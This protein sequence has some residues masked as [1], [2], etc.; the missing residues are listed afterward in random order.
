[1]ASVVVAVGV[2]A[3]VTFQ[4]TPQYA[5]SARLFVST[6]TGDSGEAYQ[7]SLFSAQRV[8][9]YADLAT[10]EELSRRVVEAN[11]LDMDADDLARQ[12][13][14]TVVPETV[15]LEITVTD[16]SPERAQRLAQAVASELTVFVAE[17]ERPEGRSNAPIKA[18][19]VD[20]A[21]SPE[22]PV[23][24]QPVRNLGLAAVLGLLLGLGLAVLR[25]LLDTSV[26]SQEDV[27]E[28]TGAPVMGH[29]SY[30]AGAVKKP[31]ITDLG[32]HAPRVEAFRVLRTNMQFVN[33]DS[34]SKVFVVTSSVPEEGKTTT[35]TNLAITL[36]QAGQRV[37]LIEADLR[38]PKISDNL[39]LEMVVGLTTVLVGRI[40]LED[41]VQ[42]FTVPNL[43]VLT[44]GAIP[45]NPSELLQSHAM[46]DVLDQARKMYDIIILDA[47]PLLPVTDAAL[48]TAQSDGALL[49]VRHGS[50]TKEQLRHS[51]ERLE[52]VEG[53][54]LG[55]VINM[56]P[57]RRS[58]G[59][60]DGY[61]YSYGYAPKPG[62]RGRP[63]GDSSN[64]SEPASSLDEIGFERN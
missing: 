14:A 4:M 47:P 26:K 25:E 37:L 8:L 61:G 5:S 42:E 40:S 11:A 39:R 49:V 32:S 43:S 6:S 35:A 34:D 33:V 52:A 10:G 55:V 28:T 19:I 41:A 17:L 15:I 36:A 57:S 23:S 56:V 63:K 48:L 59:Y 18:S 9:S 3:L 44:S 54:T 50:T 30:D 16:P 27:T 58:G 22:A 60:G 62:R 7:G 13:D 20:P 24:P 1:M 12:I 21:S 29:I 31:L 46:R 38:R 51:I 45:P 2:A 53:R 64:D